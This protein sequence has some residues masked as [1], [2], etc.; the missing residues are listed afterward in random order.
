MKPVA[1]RLL[2]LAALVCASVVGAPAALAQG[3]FTP[4]T[5]TTANCNP[6]NPPTTF[7]S[8]SCTSGS[9][10]VT[11]TAW[12]YTNTLSTSTAKTGWQQGRIGD[13]NSSGFGAYTGNKESTSDSQHAFDNVTSGCGNSSGADSGTVPLSTANGGCGG[14]VEAVLLDF[15]G[16][17]IRLSQIGIGYV[18]GDA[19]MSIYAWTGAASAPT[20]SSQTLKNSTSGAGVLDGWTL[21]GSKDVDALTNDL[22]DTGSNLYSSYFLVTTYFGATTGSG[23]SKLDMGNDK[24]KINTFTALCNGSCSPPPSQTS[25]PEPASLAL[26]SLAL[27]GVFGV[28]RKSRRSA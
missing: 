17:D 2:A 26:A 1:T 27:A 23:S 6:K 22:W 11:M 5:G 12:G 21:V 10:S 9:L 16:T 3:T 19:D 15:G 18:S 8:V 24:F 4:G 28:R 14:A 20:M 13:F 7:D 25:V